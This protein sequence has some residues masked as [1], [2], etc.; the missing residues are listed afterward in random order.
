MVDMTP[1]GL[2]AMYVSTQMLHGF[3]RERRRFFTAVAEQFVARGTGTSI[4]FK[5][6]TMLLGGMPSQTSPHKRVRLRRNHG[7]SQT[8]QVGSR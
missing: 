3:G 1:L 2:A 5:A 7:L 6:G 4:S 8:P